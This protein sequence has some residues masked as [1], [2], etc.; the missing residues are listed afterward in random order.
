MRTSLEFRVVCLFESSTQVRTRDG[1][2]NEEKRDFKV[3]TS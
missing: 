1:F 3:Q 2:E